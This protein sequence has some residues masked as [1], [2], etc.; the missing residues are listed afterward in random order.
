MEKYRLFTSESVSEGHPDKVCDQISDAIIDAILVRDENARVACETFI[1]NDFVLISGEITTVAIVNYEEIARGVLRRIGYTDKSLGINADNCEVLIKIN[2]QSPD[3]DKA[4][5]RDEIE[6][7]GAGDQGMMFGYASRETAGLMPLAP[8]LAHKL[9]RIATEKRKNGEFKH[10]RPDMKAQVT[11]RYDENNNISIDTIIISIQHERNIDMDAF[12]TYVY[13]EII[14]PVTNSFG[15]NADF[16]YYINPGGDFVIGGPEADAGLTGRKII[17]DTYG[18]Y[19]RHGGG[20]F[21]GKDPSKVDRS[22]AYMARYIAKNIVAANLASKVEVQLSYAI[23]VAA[24]IS[25]AVDTF[26][27]ANKY[28][29][30]E[31]LRAIKHVFDCRAGVMIRDFSLTKPTFAYEDL[32]AL[33]HF[34]RPD[35]NVPWEK[36][37]K[38]DALLQ[39]LQKSA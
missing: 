29:E 2:E 4:V 32:A 33:G 9:M 8:V 30:Y 39:F 7:Q 12:R 26:G 10:A 38:V 34:G 6:K 15:L 22:G 31:I 21:S 11:V 19:A 24:P 27:T 3:I 17:V 35:L 25:I 20:A 14:V 23:G 28:E 5:S 13:N 1:T 16:K 36:V 18:G 37:D